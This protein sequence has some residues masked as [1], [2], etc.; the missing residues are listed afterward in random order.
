MKDSP[1][2]RIKV[3]V[4]WWFLN[5]GKAREKKGGK[6]GQCVKLLSAFLS[7]RSLPFFKREKDKSTEKSSK[8]VFQKDQ[9]IVSLLGID[10]I[11]EEEICVFLMIKKISAPNFV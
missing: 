10:C 6:R 1:K 5:K 2:R 11:Y 4:L 8:F 7:R 3:L 9:C